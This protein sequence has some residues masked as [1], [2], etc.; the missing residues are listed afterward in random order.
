MNRI[1]RLS[2]II[3]QLQSRKTVRAQDIAERFDISLRTVYRDIRSLEEAGIPIIGEA[4]V[5]YSLVEGYRL[6]PVMFTREEA[7]AFI[8]AEKLVTRLTDAANGALYN[9]AL[10]K[11]R[12]VLKTTEKD[13]LENI[14]NR[15]EVFKSNRLPDLNP[16]HNPLQNILKAIAVKAVIQLEYFAY[17]RQEHTKRLVEPIGVFYL[18]GYWHLIAWCRER[19]ACRDFRFDR[20]TE[21]SLTDETYVDVHCAF[22][23]YLD[24]LYKEMK[25]EEVT[26]LVDHKANQHLGEQ[27][28]YQGFV[29][30]QHT[31]QGVEMQ[32]LTMSMEGFARW[33]MS[34]ADYATVIKPASLLTRVKE[35]NSATAK[36]IADK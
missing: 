8:T 27:K 19:K 24:D 6:P 10:D 33:Y 7:V 5:G 16:Q 35:I 30:E 25:L 21:L 15:I 9:T 28:Y 3:I 32:F 26:I 1:D 17:Y 12:A 23:D 2:A 22:K 36:K 29:E 14:D 34:F 18:Q 20:I 4:G 13:Y 31:A 11:V